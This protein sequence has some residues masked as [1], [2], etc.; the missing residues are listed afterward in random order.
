[1]GPLSWFYTLRISHF[2]IFS[3]KQTLVL[4]SPFWNT[5]R[6]FTPYVESKRCPQK[7]RNSYNGVILRLYAQVLVPGVWPGKVMLDET[8]KFFAQ[9]NYSHFSIRGS[10]ACPPLCIP[11]E[12]RVPSTSKENTCQIT[13]DHVHMI[14]EEDT[15]GGCVILCSMWT[16]KILNG[17]FNMTR[18]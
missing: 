18:K 10:F 5:L 8:D 7:V 11:L 9:V 2:G 1:M 13:S 12:G 14:S 17:R 4:I 6:P 3:L 16:E 15:A